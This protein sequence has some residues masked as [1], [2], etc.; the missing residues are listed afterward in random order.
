MNIRTEL[1]CCNVIVHVSQ[2]CLYSSFTVRINLKEIDVVDLIE[3]SRLSCA[4]THALGIVNAN[5]IIIKLVAHLLAR[6]KKPSDQSKTSHIYY[7]RFR[8]DLLLSPCEVL[9]QPHNL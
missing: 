5:K 7:I 1:I 3:G 9:S 2:D 6:K 8:G 4:C